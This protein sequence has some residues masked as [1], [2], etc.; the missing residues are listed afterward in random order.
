MVKAHRKES[1]ESFMYFVTCIMLF[2]ATDKNILYFT[3]RQRNMSDEEGF[4][5][6]KLESDPFVMQKMKASLIGCL[7]M[8]LACILE[9]FG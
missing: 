7:L 2:V 4:R 5:D 3:L 8:C 9:V 6:R 1:L